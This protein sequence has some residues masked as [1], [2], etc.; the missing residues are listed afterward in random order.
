MSHA[1]PPQALP[2]G[3]IACKTSD[4]QPYYFN[5][6]TDTSSWHLPSSTPPP[7]SAS[8]PGPPPAPPPSA[9]S[10]PAADAF[11]IS[12]TSVASLHNFLVP[13]PDV[14]CRLALLSLLPQCFGLAPQTLEDMLF[15]NG[16]E[17]EQ[18]Q[19]AG[20]ADLELKLAVRMFTV[21]QPYPLYRSF[22]NPFFD[23]VPPLL[24]PVCLSP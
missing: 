16:W 8:P 3:W 5:Q 9:P 2:H 11:D 17:V 10:A 18:V 13:T 20:L 14:T 23:K 22:N 21:E 7:Q 1:P 15:A 12:G 19:V 6:L 24:P 4:G